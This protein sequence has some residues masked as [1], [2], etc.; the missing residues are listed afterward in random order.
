MIMNYEEQILSKMANRQKVEV[1]V[2]AAV[3]KSLKFR[4]KTYYTLQRTRE[5]YLEKQASN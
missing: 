5:I 2:N 3:E 1:F 4:E